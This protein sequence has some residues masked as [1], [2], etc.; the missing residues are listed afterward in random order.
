MS[1]QVTS[2]VVHFPL[3]SVAS[4]PLMWAQ[5]QRNRRQTPFGFEF[6]QEEEDCVIFLHR[7]GSERQHCLTLFSPLLLVLFFDRFKVFPVE[8]AIGAE[9]TIPL[10][11]LQFPWH[12]CLE[13]Q[14]FEDKVTAASA[15][16]LLHLLSCYWSCVFLL[17]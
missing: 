5:L 13:L 7:R 14:M 11:E 4:C 16:A 15:K 9:H 8:T 2:G 6:P 3:M 1:L 17:V 12:H 10:V